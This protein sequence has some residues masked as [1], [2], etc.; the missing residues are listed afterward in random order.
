MN[1]LNTSSSLSLCM[2]IRDEAKYLHD[3]LQSVEDVVDQIVIVDTGSTDDS[4]KIARG[5]GAEIYYF[6]W[7]NDFSRA[8][9]F[10]IKHA[11]SDWILW[12]DADERLIPSSVNELRQIVSSVGQPTIYRIQIQNRMLTG[13]YCYHSIAHRLFT[14]HHGI[15]FSGKIHEQVSPSAKTIDAIERD[16]GIVLDHLGYG[17]AAAEMAKK[18]KRNG[19]LLEKQVA[20]EPNNAYAHYTLAQNYGL[21]E[22]LTAA[23]EHYQRALDL[24]QL[25]R[26]MTASLL[27]SL[28]DIHRLNQDW[29][30]ASECAR[31]SVKLFPRQV[32]GNY[33]LYQVASATGDQSAA[34]KW[35]EKTAQ[36]NHLLVT[37]P[38]QLATDI[39]IDDLR[40]QHNLGNEYL[41]AGNLQKAKDC[42]KVVAKHKPGQQENNER[43]AE[44]ARLENDLAGMEYYYSELY[45]DFPDNPIYTDLLGLVYIK[46]K[47][48]SQ[49]I[50]IYETMIANN[51]ANPNLIKRL[52]GLYGI[53]GDNEKSV[54]L[55][56]GVEDDS[57]RKLE[58]AENEC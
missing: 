12:I 51:P 17:L 49:A 8:R 52:A 30:P 55:L 26:S 13:A 39:Q 31:Q 53:I 18:F 42:Y 35:L 2:I 21:Q 34:I 7:A 56:A 43:L 15:K 19:H 6:K 1:R 23:I 54:K 36:N 33:L 24:K 48:Y 11:R 45:R 40:L 25:D 16:S 44:I 38:K 46:Q 28:G 4:V 5:F 9:N 47:K 32:A 37:L 41:K 58:K 29:S 14:N 50:D 57:L 10:S 3:C 27:N 22:N 20:D